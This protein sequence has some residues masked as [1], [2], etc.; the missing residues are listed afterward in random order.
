MAQR[1]RNPGAVAPAS[2]FEVINGTM[3]QTELTNTGDAKRHLLSHRDNGTP[4][5]RL[6]LLQGLRPDWVKVFE[7]YFGL[8][9]TFLESHMRRRPYQHHSWTLPVQSGAFSVSYPEIVRWDSRSTVRK[10]RAASSGDQNQS[11]MKVDALFDPVNSPFEGLTYGKEK[12]VGALLNHAA[13]WNRI[14]R[15]KNIDCK[16][17]HSI[18]LPTHANEHLRYSFI[19]PR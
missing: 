1:S 13:S 9:A 10:S 7:D 11:P 16:C 2:V 12:D 6:Y 15:N 19:T 4:H 17:V 5:F 3:Q 8:N 14:H 18:S